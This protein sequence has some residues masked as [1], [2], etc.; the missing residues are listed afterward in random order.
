[1]VIAKAKRTLDSD[2]KLRKEINELL[3]E[4]GLDETGEFKSCF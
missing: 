1:M 2:R 3:K 4:E